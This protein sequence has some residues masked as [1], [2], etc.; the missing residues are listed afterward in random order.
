MSTKE[1]SPK[2]SEEVSQIEGHRKSRRKSS[3]D[4]IKRGSRQLTGISMAFSV[5]QYKRRWFPTIIVCALLLADLVFMGLTGYLPVT[6][7][8]NNPDIGWQRHVLSGF[9]G[10]FAFLS[11]LMAWYLGTAVY[12]AEYIFVDNELYKRIRAVCVLSFIDMVI[13]LIITA[14]APFEQQAAMLILFGNAIGLVLIESCVAVAVYKK[15]GFLARIF[16]PFRP[17][18]FV[19]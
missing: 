2:M 10:F 11:L 13:N 15:R 1:A 16:L 4:P 5:V 8:K 7:F 9:C 6:I 3:I 14:S 17:T 12:R 19:E 18:H